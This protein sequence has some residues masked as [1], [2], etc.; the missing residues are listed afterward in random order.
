MLKL[1]ITSLFR[2]LFGEVHWTYPGWIRVIIDFVF[3]NKKV[4]LSFLG[5]IFIVSISSIGF[6]IWKSK[7]P[8]PIKF[9]VSG[10]TPKSKS[11]DENAKPNNLYM[12]FGGSVAPLSQIGKEIRNNIE[13]IPEIKGQWQWY[14]ENQIVFEPIEDWKPGVEYIV[15]LKKK[16]FPEHIYLDKY[17][18]KFRVE[19]ISLNLV[20]REFYTSPKD[21][22]DK[23]V[24][25]EIKSNYSIDPRKFENL[26]HLNISEKK[27]GV[28]IVSPKKIK[29]EVKY[30][31][32]KSKA[33]IISEK[34]KIPLEPQFMELKVEEGTHSIL[35]GEPYKFAISDRVKIPSMYDYFKIDNLYIDFVKN[36]KHE[37]DQVLM[38]ET[39]NR[40]SSEKVLEYFQV[41]QL[42]QDKPAYNGLGL[43]KDHYWY[44]DE[45]NSFF[46]SRSQKLNLKVIPSSEE[47]SK[48]HS[49][50]I[51]AKPNRSLYCKIRSG[52]PSRGGFILAKDFQEIVEV[53]AYPEELKILHEGSVLSLSGKKELTFLNR[54]VS[55]VKIQLNRIIPDQIQHLI[56]QTEGLYN[57]PYFRDYI[58]NEENISEVF[59]EIKD[60]PSD[61]QGGRVRYSSIDFSKYLEK[62]GDQKGLFILKISSW[63]KRYKYEMSPEDKRLILVTDIGILVKKNHDKNYHVFVQSIRD[64][65]PLYK[66]DVSILAKN[67]SILASKKTD[68]DGH[69]QFDSY[70]EFKNEKEPVAFIVKRKNDFSFI[71]YKS[72]SRSLNFSQFDTG[73]EWESEEIDES[74]LKTFLFSDRGI[75]RPGEKIQ[76]GGMLKSK[77]WSDDISGLPLLIN[78]YDARGF[79]INSSHIQI[80]EN[81]LFESEYLTYPESPTGVYRADL[82]LLENNKQSNFLDSIEVR[83]EEFQPDRLKIRTYFSNENQKAWLKPEKLNAVVD[84]KYLFGAPAHGNRVDANINLVPWKS[85]FPKYHNYSFFDPNKA[86]ES[87]QEKLS[88]VNTNSEGEAFLN[89]DLSYY[90]KA[91]YNLYLFT[92]GFETSTGG[93]SVLSKDSILISSQDYLIGHKSEQD[94]QYLYQDSQAKI[95]FIAV[96]DE[97]EKVRVKDIKISL[98]RKETVSVLAQQDNGLYRYQTVEKDRTLNE[99]S[100]VISEKGSRYKINTQK[101]GSYKIVIRNLGGEI[102]SSVP[103]HVRGEANLSA[104]LE[105]NSEL[106]ITLSKK[107]FSA[108]EEIEFQIQAPYV[109]SGLIS[110]ER[111]KVFTYKWFKTDKTHSIQKIKLPQDF[112]GNGY[113]H[114]D[115][116]RDLDSKEI[117]VS[118]L[119]YGVVPFRTNYGKRKIDITLNTSKKVKPGEN[120]QVKYKSNKSAKV[121]IYAVDE[122]ILQVSNYKT[123]NPLKHFFRKKA[124]QVETMQI[125]DL[126]LPEINV[127][128]QSSRFGGDEEI[129]L[130]KNLNPFKRK[131]DK[132][133]IFW[134]GILD[135]SSE[136]KLLEFKVPD[137]FNGNMRIMAVASNQTALGS[138]TTHSLVRSP[139]VINPQVPLFIS[140]GD[141]FEVKIGLV[142]NPEE[143][144]PNSELNLVLNDNDFFE[145]LSPQ[146]HSFKLSDQK[147]NFFSFKLR[148]KAKLGSSDLSFQVLS[149][150]K[151]L[152][153]I[154]RSLS[155]RPTTHF[156][157]LVRSGFIDNDARAYDLRD[158]LY[159]NF[160][161][162]GVMLSRDPLSLSHGLKKYLKDFPYQCTEQLIS[163]F[164]PVISLS[165]H[166]KFFDSNSDKDFKRL[167]SQLS[168]R[169]NSKGQFGYWSGNSFTNDFINVYAA[170]FLILAKEKGFQISGPVLDDVLK[171]L[172]SFLLTHPQDIEQIRYQ[173]YA[174]YLLTD[175]GYKLTNHLERIHTLLK[176]KYENIWEKDLTA[177]YLA[178]T[179]KILKQNSEAEKILSKVKWNNGI[180]SNYDSFYNS[181][182]RNSQFLYVLAR[183]F[184]DQ[185]QEVKTEDIYELLKPLM[186][187]KYN[188]VSSAYLILGLSHLSLNELKLDTEDLV[189]VVDHLSQ[190]QQINFHGDIWYQA[191]LYQNYDKL[192]L[193]DSSENYYY[194]I[195][196]AGFDKDGPTKSNDQY[197]EIYREFRKVGNDKSSLD[198]KIGDQIE[199]IL[200]VR[201]KHQVTYHDM[202]L[203]HL[204]PAGFEIDF[205]SI[206]RVD[207]SN[208]YQFPHYVDVREDRLL[209]FGVL[210]SKMK[211]YK[212]RLKAVTPG[213]FN[214]PAV[215]VESMYY[216]EI[217]G[218]SIQEKV[219]V[220]Q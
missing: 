10:S 163:Q 119:S 72:R 25:F 161:S 198:F 61:D 147:E 100:Y 67:G 185:F 165:K 59:S 47:F 18:Y 38:I 91:N 97:L 184:P 6:E 99:M 145:N 136:E 54:D 200:K 171:Y 68:K 162:Q 34:I 92:E 113:I 192:T 205:D 31:E 194:Q 207:T 176:E 129:N 26:I 14:S 53:Q 139:I 52:L 88:S 130:R 12:Y 79:L 86:H 208:Y 112:E 19:E 150:G 157:S 209:L 87:Y 168:L 179:Y 108:G 204:L 8:Q 110:I 187:H 4:F 107:E 114:V 143:F 159:K 58:F 9:S 201:T 22:S 131:T 121:I 101:P 164:F 160:R 13:I 178:A 51:N 122:G 153:Q 109:G 158:N 36:E 104:E 93:R 50:K 82:F 116:V 173:A 89:I 128:E 69:V 71:P 42:P 170:H 81:G 133:A 20:N 219:K 181:T 24:I 177:I 60:F 56:S 23:R 106:K 77:K 28:Q 213:E 75:Y 1:I 96:N 73:G 65:E 120:I 123:P 202:A 167:I 63:D 137:T 37:T 149:Q 105:K 156:Q 103:Y 138:T 174:L 212:F 83:V 70:D 17:E 199:V 152:S 85:A 102:L 5:I 169:Q 16:L 155:V 140:P 46:L 66:A 189:R 218:H 125:L 141:I 220:I 3:H 203:I 27:E 182:I 210:D 132:P 188:T 180:Y 166:P 148:A 195:S 124:L 62:S 197:I 206:K 118:P 98:V 95:E 45:I 183:H 134:S 172:N 33:T 29:W 11:F 217:K 57:D 154:N 76:F 21:P 7:Q 39:T 215:Y 2:L 43:E 175:Q 32:W 127:R 135:I 35:G 214:L 15:H 190:E 126:L 84:L 115:F 151:K 30:D 117:Y 146:S 211:E 44:T 64:K 90:D 55:H 216:P 94:L 78:L 142:P 191:P 40:V 111:E 48:V 80:D 49:F 41:Y 193:K 144:S 196:E 74:N 186:N